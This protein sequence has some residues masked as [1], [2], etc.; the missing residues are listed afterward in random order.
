LGPAMLHTGFKRY[1]H[2]RAIGPG[3]EVEI[4]AGTAPA[5]ATRAERSS[6]IDSVT[7]RLMNAVIVVSGR[8]HRLVVHPD[9]GLILEVD[10]TLVNEFVGGDVNIISRIPGPSAQDTAAMSRPLSVLE[11]HELKLLGRRLTRGTWGPMLGAP[12]AAAAVVGLVWATTAD[13]GAAPD[14][15]ITVLFTSGPLLLVAAVDRWQ[16]RRLAAKLQRD[17]EAGLRREEGRWLLPESGICWESNGLPGPLRLVG[18][19]LGSEA[20]GRTRPVMF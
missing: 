19:G 8:N 2:L 11:K 9:T 10:G 1:R 14:V 13:R 17:S 16:R 18:G 5:P 12:S 4:F 6:E 20:D 7:A 15:V 3:S